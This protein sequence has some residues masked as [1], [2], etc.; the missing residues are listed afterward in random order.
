M[1][2]IVSPSEVQILVT[3]SISGNQVD[4]YTKEMFMLVQIDV[5]K[6][7]TIHQRLVVTREE[8]D[9]VKKTAYLFQSEQAWY[10][11]KSHYLF[12]ELTTVYIVS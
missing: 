3:K 5:S 2:S 4:K 12:N 1:E 8:A 6:K 9:V 7:P 11:Y 10:D